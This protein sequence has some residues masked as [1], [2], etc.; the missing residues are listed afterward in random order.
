M[1]RNWSPDVKAKIMEAQLGN[2]VGSRIEIVASIQSIIAAKVK[3]CRMKLLGARF[4]DHGHGT[5]RRQAVFCTVI[6]G[7][8]SELGDGIHRWQNIS[9]TTTSTI[10]SL[11]PINQPEVVAD[12]LA[13]K[14][15]I[16]IAAGRS[17]N[18][19]ICL[20]AGSASRESLQLEHAAAIGGKL[21][22]LLAGNHAADF[23]SIGLYSDRIGFD[24]NC[25]LYVS[26]LQ[27][28]INAGAV[29]DLQRDTF[30]LGVFEAARYST[31]DVMPNV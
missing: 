30:L 5:C 21:R 6:R 28:E 9:P 19:E 17:R 11:T 26:N 4:D 25:L 20:N 23:A 1:E 15:H 13:I 22:D 27:F 2:F 10:G 8:R 31:D 12:T 14:T 18:L 3:R 24:S 16:E 7:H 29:A